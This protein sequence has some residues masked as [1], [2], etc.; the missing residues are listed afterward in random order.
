[1]MGSR[2]SGE[3]GIWPVQGLSSWLLEMYWHGSKGKRLGM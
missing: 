1:M 3:G 2:F